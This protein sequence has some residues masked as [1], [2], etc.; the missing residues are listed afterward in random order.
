MRTYLLDAAEHWQV[1]V[2]LAALAGRHAAD[3]LR[4][5]LDGLLGVEGA[6]FIKKCSEGKYRVH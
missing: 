3:H 5:V 6:L 2:R 1:H 4:A